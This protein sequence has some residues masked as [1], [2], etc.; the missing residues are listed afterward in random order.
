M[1]VSDAEYRPAWLQSEAG[2]ERPGI[3][4]VESEPIDEL[5]DFGNGIGVIAR[6]GHGEAIWRAPRSPSLFKLEVAEW[7]R[8][9]TTLDDE[10]RGCTT[11]LV[12]CGAV[13]S[14]SSIPSTSS[15]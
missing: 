8:L 15:Q 4:G 12:P 11:M 13:A 6:G 3:N 9:L 2:G 14:S 1:T 7:L 5:H 10:K